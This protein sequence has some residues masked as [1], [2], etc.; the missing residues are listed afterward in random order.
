M[1][2]YKFYRDENG[3]VCEHLNN[4][5]SIIKYNESAQEILTSLFKRK[6]Y[7]VNLINN[8]MTQEENTLR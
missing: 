5:K 1:V 8:R 6:Y 2:Y 7:A 3:F 4:G